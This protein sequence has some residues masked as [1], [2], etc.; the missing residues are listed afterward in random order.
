MGIVYWIPFATTVVASGFAGVVLRRWRTRHGMHLL[1]WGIGLLTYAAG[2][3]TESLTTLFGWNPWLFRA[4]YITGALCGGA[5]LAQGTVYLLMPR[6]FADATAAARAQSSQSL[7]P[8][9]ST[10]GWRECAS[11]ACRSA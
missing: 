11:S 7:S 3:L 1:W 6:R 5:P 8:G 10:K 4:W 2:T 9:S